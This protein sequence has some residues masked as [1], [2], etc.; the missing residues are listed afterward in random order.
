MWCTFHEWDDYHKTMWN[1]L[2]PSI[3]SFISTA[4]LL[5]FK[6]LHWLIK[7]FGFL[8]STLYA[9]LI[10]YLNLDKRREDSACICFIL[11]LPAV[12]FT[13]GI[14][15]LYSTGNSDL[16]CCYGT[17]Y[18]LVLLYLFQI[19]CV[20]LFLVVLVEMN[21]WVYSLF[22]VPLTDLILL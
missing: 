5:S 12:M 15:L 6:Y 17:V 1:R 10:E 14:F 18:R 9:F 21:F 8:I 3:Q 20:I 22:T 11:V 13:L 2:D 7:C 4:G 16:C 19:W